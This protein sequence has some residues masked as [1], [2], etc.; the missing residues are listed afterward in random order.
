M[1]KVKIKCLHYVQW[2][3]CILT[4][5]FSNVVVGAILFS[6]NLEQLYLNRNANVIAESETSDKLGLSPKPISIL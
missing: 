5:K 3:P 1:F 2:I 4:R 6:T